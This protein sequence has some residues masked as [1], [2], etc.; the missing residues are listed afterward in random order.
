MYLGPFPKVSLEEELADARRE[1][2]LR[3]TAVYPNLV[4]T[5]KLARSTAEH[6]IA[7]QR[8]IVGRL[9][10]ALSLVQPPQLTLGL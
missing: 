1:L 10:A 2:T 4:R 3:E 9:E 5:G 6:R 8:A 7:C